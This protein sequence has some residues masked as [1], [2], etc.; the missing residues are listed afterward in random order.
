MARL[1]RA[2]CSGPGFRASGGGAAS[3]TS[4]RT[5]D[6]IDEADVVARLRP[7]VIPPAWSDVW[8]CPAP[9][10]SAG[11][12]RGRGRPAPV[13]LPRRLAPAGGPAEVRRD[14]RP[15]EGA[16]RPAGTRRRR[17]EAPASRERVLAGACGC[18]TAASSASGPSSTPSE[19]SFGLATMRE[20]HVTCAVTIV[21]DY[22]KA[23][24]ATGPAV[25]DPRRG[26]RRRRSGAG[27][28]AARSCSP[29]RAGGRWR[30]VRSGDVNE[31][32]KVATGRGPAPRISARG[33][34]PSSPPSRS[35]CRRARP[36]AAAS[37]RSREPSARSPLPRQHPGRLPLLLHR[38]A[39]L[40]RLR[41]RPVSSAR[42]RRPPRRRREL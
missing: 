17:L 38:P 10:P 21:F 5:A 42:A 24:E 20:S 2:D 19:R 3:A 36:R 32:L 31:Y 14:D 7:L 12:G 16:A 23:R 6:P 11:D 37:A 15:R 18:S 35:L 13:P 39:G 27:A 33:T 29:T 26:R 30:D 41:G 28:V 22:V 34:P 9:R 8:I 1:R 4:T 25:L 40:R